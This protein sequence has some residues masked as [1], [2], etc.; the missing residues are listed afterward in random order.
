[1]SLRSGLFV[2]GLILVLS[3]AGCGGGN[4]VT[5][6]G[7]VPV[8]G[9][10]LVDGKPLD[11]VVLT[12]VPEI[13]E[14]NR[15]GAGET[16]ASGAFTVTHLNAQEPGLPPGKYRIYY[17]RMRLPDG[18]AAPELKEGEQPDPD[19]IQV[20]T[21]PTHLTTSDPQYPAEMVEIP[22]GGNTNLELSIS[23]KEPSGATGPR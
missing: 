15:G 3:V 5:V 17:S 2:A 14:N 18:S 20:E 21:L 10:L 8:G 11:G 19:N 7:L 12:F 23:T 9:T 1:M 4:T 6:E 22:E 13:S 16:D